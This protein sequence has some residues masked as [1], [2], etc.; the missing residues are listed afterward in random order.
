MGYMLVRLDV[1]SHVQVFQQKPVGRK[2][3]TQPYSAT[4]SAGYRLT[5]QEKREKSARLEYLFAHST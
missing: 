5:N 3:M 4:S 2:A 1:K